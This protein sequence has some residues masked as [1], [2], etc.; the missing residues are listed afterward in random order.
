MQMAQHKIGFYT[1]KGYG[2]EKDAKAAVGWYEKACA[3]G[4]T[5]SRIYCSFY[6][7]F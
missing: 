2:C 4:M 3:E 6:V 5:N 7:T 1:E